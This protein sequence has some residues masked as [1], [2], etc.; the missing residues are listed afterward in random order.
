MN[1]RLYYQDAYTTEFTAVITDRIIEN[2]RFAVTLDQT[3]FYPTS[4]GQPFDKGTL[5][6]R[7]VI[8]VTV[9]EEDGAVLH[10]LDGAMPENNAVTAVIDWPRR[11]DHMQQHTGQHILSQ[12]FIRIAEAYTIG[13][14]LS[15]DT[16][17][18]DLNVNKLSAEQLNQVEQLANDIVW[19]NRPVHIQLVTRAEAEKMPIRKIPPTP[20]NEIRLIG[21]EDFDLTACGGTHVLRTGSV[22]LIKI[23]KVE[24][25]GETTRIEFRCGGRAVSDYG[26]K[27]DTIQELMTALTTGQESL[28]TAV[29]SL[30]DEN[31][32]SQRTIKKLQSNLLEYQAA[33]MI[34]AGQKTGE[35]ILISQVFDENEGINL[36]HLGQHLTQQSGVVALLATTGTKSQLLFCRSD[37]A[38][39][40]MN[41][42]LKE[43][44]NQI[45]GRGGGSAVMAQGGGPGVENGRLSQILAHIQQIIQ[46][47]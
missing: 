7:S 36:R 3:Y 23:V 44:L 24:R 12:A 14:H 26:R 21:I 20:T 38:P 29:S 41:T 37:N 40:D 30:Q 17:T 15:D 31:K 39:G 45:D 32:N 4:G 46:T 22:G 43:A 2:G 8:D 27:N 19:Q 5:D 6:G 16:V 47:K 28:V 10:W 33:Q 11:F 13:F 18:I 35:F 42:L 34:H 1:H 25:R 9:R